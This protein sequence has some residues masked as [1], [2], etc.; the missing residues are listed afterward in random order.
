MVMVWSD[1]KKLNSG[2]IKSILSCYGI[3]YNAKNQS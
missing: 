2:S 1:C 3:N